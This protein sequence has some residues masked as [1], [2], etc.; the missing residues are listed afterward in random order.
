MIRRTL[1]I[2]VAI[3]GAAVLVLPAGTAAAHH[4]G[5]TAATDCATGTEWTATVTTRFPE[6]SW[7]AGAG[8]A[9]VTV[10]PSVGDPWSFTLAGPGTFDVTARTFDVGSVT[11]VASAVWANG[12]TWTGSIT[13]V[14]PPW[15]PQPTTTTVATVPPTDPPPPPTEPTVPPTDPTVPPTNPTTTIPETTTTWATTPPTDPP[16]T[17]TTSTQPPG[18]TSS[19]TTNPP[20]STTSST[21]APP[22]TVSTSTSTPGA[23]SSTSSVPVSTL[24]PSSTAPGT[25]QIPTSSIVPTSAPSSTLATASSTTPRTWPPE[26]PPCTEVTDPL[27][28]CYRTPTTPPPAGALPATGGTAGPLMLAGCVLLLAGMF[29]VVVAARRQS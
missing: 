10:T 22:T 8:A 13:E 24:P 23:T 14:R 9:G 19:T 17:T 28:A 29:A 11:F 7:A 5:L 12:Q 16:T 18:S 6:A 1:A 15:C 3:L 21:V 27:T 2:L 20:T 25:T 4:L 26:E